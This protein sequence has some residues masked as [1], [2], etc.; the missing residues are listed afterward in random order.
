[1][2]KGDRDHPDQLVL[3][4]EELDAAVASVRAEFDATGDKLGA[5]HTQHTN[6]GALPSHLERIKQIAKW[7]ARPVLAAARAL[8]HR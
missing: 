6:R 2:Q 4:L 8:R 1:M 5:P 3:A 7:R